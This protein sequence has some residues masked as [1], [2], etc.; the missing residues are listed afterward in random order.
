VSGILELSAPL[1]HFFDQAVTREEAIL[2]LV[3]L[4]EEKGYVKP[5]FGQACIEREKVFPTGLPTEPFGIAIPHTDCEHVE[6]GAIAVGVLPETVQFVEMGCLDDSF[7]DV[8]VIVVLAIADPQAVASVLQELA[9]AFQDADFITGLTQAR[10]A[11]AVLALFVERTPAVVKVL[12]S[13]VANEDA[14]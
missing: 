9:L 4:L 13:H 1:V 2:G 3:S 10:T 14:S 6:R 5:S 12:P 8:H 11:D 7:V